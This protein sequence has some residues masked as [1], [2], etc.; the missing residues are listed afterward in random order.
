MH[1]NNNPRMP[2][3]YM[4]VCSFYVPLFASTYITKP[5]LIEDFTKR[6]VRLNAIMLTNN[7]QCH[8]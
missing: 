3:H 4:N 6:K 7:Q 5:D 1:N 8:Q 2:Y